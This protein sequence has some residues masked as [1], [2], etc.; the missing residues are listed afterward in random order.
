MAS[1]LKWLFVLVSF[2][3]LNSFAAEEQIKFLTK[4]I[5]LGKK[6]IQVEIADTEQQQS[7]GLMFR[8]KMNAEGGMLFVFSDEQTRSFWM[9]NTLI[10]LSI[11]YFNK[12]KKLID[13][14]DMSATSSIM[15]QSLP[16]YISKSPAMYALEMN[17]GWFKKNKIK[18]GSI[19]KFISTGP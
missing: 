3:S 6:L 2:F 10:D 4:K 14:Q 8:K 11:G 15:Q 18:L 17:K 19:F 7:Q 1:H 12:E 16:T 13:I 9:K 5:Q